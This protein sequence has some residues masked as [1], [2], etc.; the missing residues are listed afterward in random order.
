MKV[1]SDS[2]S[3]NKINK[4]VKSKLQSSFHEGWESSEEGD[5]RGGRVG[6]DFAHLTEIQFQNSRNDVW[7]C[8]RQVSMVHTI[9]K[10]L[11]RLNKHSVISIKFLLVISML[12]QPLRL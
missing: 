12:I 5:H 9:L 8:V 3:W 1:R 6:K 2:G 11:W 10:C 7:G 4:I